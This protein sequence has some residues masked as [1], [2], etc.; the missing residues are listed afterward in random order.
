[1]IFFGKNLNTLLT[2]L[3]LTVIVQV[4]LKM[5]MSSLVGLTFDMR[6]I[7]YLSL[8]FLVFGLP[9]HPQASRIGSAEKSWSDVKTIKN[10]K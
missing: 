1:M 9:N 10:E 3:G 4:A 6:C 2:E 5:M 7:P 8:I